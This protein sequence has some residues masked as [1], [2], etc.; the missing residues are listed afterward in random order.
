MTVVLVDG[1]L[2]TRA[3]ATVNT[4]VSN[5]ATANAAEATTITA[6]GDVAR[7]IPAEIAVAVEDKLFNFFQTS[8]FSK[9]V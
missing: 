4:I 2:A 8:G 3:T 6:V 1:V 9:F 7:C 5:H